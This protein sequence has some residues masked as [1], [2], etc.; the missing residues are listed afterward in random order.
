MIARVLSTRAERDPARVFIASPTATLTYGET[1]EAAADLASRLSECAGRRVGLLRDTDAEAVLHLLAL[2]RIGAQVH[3]FPPDLDAEVV[4]ALVRGLEIDVFIAAGSETRHLGASRGA[5]A[6]ARE[7]PASEVVLFTSGTTGTP[8][9]ALHTWESLSARVRTHPELDDS[10]WLLTYHLAAF[11][12]LQVFLH[13]L[14]NGGRLVLGGG[15]P[16]RMAAIAA[17]EAVTHIS[18]TPTF[19]RLLLASA[20]SEDLARLKPRQITLGG[21]AADQQVLEAIG[22]QFP[23]AKL[24]QIYASTEMGACFSVHDGRPGFPAS[25]LDNPDLGVD[26]RIIDGELNIRSS[27]AMRGYVAADGIRTP[28]D[29]FAT[30]DL[31]ERRGDRVHFLGRLGDRI[32]VGGNKVYP[33]EVEGVVVEVPGVR[34]VRVSGTASS[35]V[36]QLVRAEVVLEPGA[37]EAEVRRKILAHCRAHLRPYMVPRKL[38]FVPELSQTAS[39]KLARK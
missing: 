3:I 7:A 39:G 20:E 2:D 16:A 21:E 22:R 35:L 10:R 8:K 14:L 15:S 23:G 36:G 5:G 18:A 1:E 38:E 9:A 29:F 32:N 30:G 17:R 6:S 28:E 26:L 13:V 27:R 33:A 37:D 11:A 24:T 12:G 19:F 34:A 4:E 25:Y 31:V